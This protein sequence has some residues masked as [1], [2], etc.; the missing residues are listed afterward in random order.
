MGTRARRRWTVRYGSCGI[1][2]Q[3]RRRHPRRPPRGRACRC[4]ACRPHQRSVRPQVSRRLFAR[5]SR[6]QSTEQHRLPQPGFV[7]IGLQQSQ[8]SNKQSNNKAKHN[9]S[10]LDEQLAVASSRPV[11]L[12]RVARAPLLLISATF[13]QSAVKLPSQRG[14]SRPRRPRLV[15]TL[16]RPNSRRQTILSLTAWLRVC[17]RSQLSR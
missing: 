13:C 14:A 16:P 10:N 15:R 3:A 7:K 4:T 9:T 8:Q 12:L 2:A 11:S 5:E 17:V 1:G 6:A